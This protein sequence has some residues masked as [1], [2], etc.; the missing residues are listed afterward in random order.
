MPT[1][2]GYL[3][4]QKP[5]LAFGRDILRETATPVA[6]NYK[7]NT[8]Q[9]FEGDYLLTFDGTRTVGLY[10]VTHDRLM[11]TNLARER[12]DVVRRMEEKIKAVIQQYNNRMIDDKLTVE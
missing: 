5:Y 11:Q 7:D 12:V 1:L 4:Y 9:L 2:L 6:F 8:Y 10:D 3:H